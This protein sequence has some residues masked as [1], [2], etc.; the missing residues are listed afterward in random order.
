[1]AD[2]VPVEFDQNKLF[3]DNDP[4]MK[5][6]LHNVGS[7]A[8][9]VSEL[10]ENLVNFFTL[11][12]F[13]LQ[14]MADP[15]ATILIP[16]LDALIAALEDLK[17]IGFG[18]LAVWP[19]EVGKLESGVD[20]TKLEEALTAMAASIGDVDPKTLKYD[21][22]QKKYVVEVENT[23][24]GANFDFTAFGNV[25]AIYDTNTTV[26]RLEVNQD[27]K[28]ILYALEQ[29]QNFLNP[30]MWD[31]G[32]SVTGNFIKQ[33]NESF[34]FRTLTPSQFV[35]EVNSSFDDT[36]DSKRPVGTGSYVA[37]VGFFAVPTHH[38]L[39][40]VVQA[41][42]NFFSN[43]V[44]NL[45]DLNDDR[46]ER[47]EL[48]DPL[49]VE[50]L[51][52][53]LNL[54]TGMAIDAVQS[55][56]DIAEMDEVDAI[57]EETSAQGTLNA[58]EDHAT[59]KLSEA[60]SQHQ[61]D[62]IAIILKTKTKNDALAEID[63]I[64][65]EMTRLTSTYTLISVQDKSN[66]IATLNQKKEVQQDIVK[67][68][69]RSLQ[70]TR[71]RLR[72]NKNI[73]LSQEGVLK[74]AGAERT[75]LQVATQNAKRK[76]EQ[77]EKELEHIEKNGIKLEDKIYGFRNTV[78]RHIPFQL[79]GTFEGDESNDY[80]PSISINVGSDLYSAI[81]TVT[82]PMFKPGTLIQQGTVFHDFTAEVVEHEPIIVKNGRV[83]K[84]TVRIKSKRG[85]IIPN[86]SENEKP[87]TPPVIALDPEGIPN[88]DGSLDSFGILKA[89][90]GFQGSRALL[91]YPLFSAPMATVPVEVPAGK[92]IATMQSNSTTLEDVL[93][94][95]IPQNKLKKIYD[96]K[97]L[98]NDFKFRSKMIKFVEG[99]SIGQPIMHEFINAGIE[100]GMEPPSVENDFPFKRGLWHLFP[101]QGFTPVIKS[102][103]IS[104][105]DPKRAT[106]EDQLFYNEV[107]TKGEK[108]FYSMNKIRL[109]IGRAVKTGSVEDYIPSHIKVPGN[110]KWYYELNDKPFKLYN[111]EGGSSGLPNWKFM[112][113]Q[114][115]FPI[116]G[117]TIDRIIDKIEFA[118]D[119]ASGALKKINEAIAYLEKLIDDLL[120]LNDAIQAVLLFFK[121]G[122]DKMGFYTAKFS[123]E[124]GVNEFKDKLLNAKIK[125]V[126]R[127]PTPEYQLKPVTT[128]QRV[129][130][131]VTGEWEDIESTIMKLTSETISQE[132]FDL[133]AREQ[134]TNGTVTELLS[135]SELDSLKYSGGFVLFG[136][137]NDAKLLDKFLKLSGLKKREEIENAS[138]E[139]DA[140]ELNTLLDQVRPYVQ[141]VQVQAVNSETFINSE[142][143]TSIKR[144]SPIKIIFANNSDQLTD[145]QKNDIKSARGTDFEF[146][147]S[148]QYGSVIPNSSANTD[149]GG[150]VVLSTDD[151]A[152]SVPL[153]FSV[154]PVYANTTS[155]LVNS[156][157]LKSK[158]SMESLTSFKLKIAK[159]IV[160]SDGITLQDEFISNSGFTTGATSV[161][162]IN[163]E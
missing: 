50:G 142:T 153:S 70:V 150:N 134:G 138:T 156:V 88:E 83:I 135:F 1:M 32:D 126:S 139:L 27:R 122:F 77:F 3:Q 13:Y 90:S 29:V 82:V 6:I 5:A 91:S 24:E 41:L 67:K 143:A 71:R 100:A 12:K 7:F 62:S 108:K 132:E 18:S 110:F 52:R 45:P 129:R 124:G 127:E 148:I 119:L 130:N 87:N 163:F 97:K 40:D 61:K 125:N 28:K 63:K 42:T 145:E 34:K 79:S 98:A 161:I 158:E 99:L 114:D 15:L 118:K 75:A 149:S 137:G 147:P 47:I 51:E 120:E 157:I 155:Q 116:Y 141:E 60:N 112:R 9:G 84:N 154:Q 73:I 2:I 17:N 133:K 53:K 44:E 115:I 20:T 140:S 37:F 96:S 43:F 105:D 76:K 111:L 14:A 54:Q 136:M 72:N 152:T 35:Q 23:L 36:N 48:G 57:G 21:P 74:S 95:D 49:V 92:F 39:R 78:K 69:N 93:P 16:A 86:T 85:K 146:D 89:G 94:A 46:I 56:I 109:E 10:I 59:Q 31:H 101:G 104:G 4:L 121:Q 106:L 107:D 38:A 19:W 64:D 103:K 33:L 128:T 66:Q 26:E 58:V 80:K 25:S 68:S 162:N 131:P 11:T 160:R 55:E 102:I 22:L 65:K 159:S 8:G 144:D 30:S 117:E 113:I 123:G 81:K 151:F